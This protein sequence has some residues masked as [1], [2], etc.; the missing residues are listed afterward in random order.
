MDDKTFTLTGKPAEKLEEFQAALVEYL[1]AYLTSKFD[2][3]VI[4][5]RCHMAVHQTENYEKEIAFLKTELA[6][7]KKVTLNQATQETLKNR[8]YYDAGFVAGFT[9]GKRSKL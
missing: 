9:A 1:T 5:E 6:E 2:Y 7:A 8:E 4:A 3:R